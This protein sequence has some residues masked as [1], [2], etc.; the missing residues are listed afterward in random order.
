MKKLRNLVAFASN[1]KMGLRLVWWRV[2]QG[3]LR[4]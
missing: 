3:G 1:H 2:A 4:R